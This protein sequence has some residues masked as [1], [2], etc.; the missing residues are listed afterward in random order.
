MDEKRWARTSEAAV[1]LGMSRDT[2]RRR[3]EDGYLIEGEHFRRGLFPNTPV[4]WNVPATREALT[5]IYP[6]RN[7]EEAGKGK[8]KG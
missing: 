1:L 5:R 3:I 8:K 7:P 4:T 6:H 2:L